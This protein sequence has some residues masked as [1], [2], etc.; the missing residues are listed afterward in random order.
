MREQS[1]ELDRLL[2]RHVAFWEHR[3]DRP[4]LDIDNYVPL[5]P[6]PDVPLLGER[7]AGA[8]PDWGA[9]AR[10]CRCPAGVGPSGAPRRRRAGR[11][12][13]PALQTAR[14]LQHL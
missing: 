1:G 8:R 7:R 11:E 3:M 2:D 12:V 13:Y 4:L 9:M 14:A 5:L 10:N 6:N